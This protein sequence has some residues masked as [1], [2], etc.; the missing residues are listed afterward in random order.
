MVPVKGPL[1]LAAFLLF[2]NDHRAMQDRT[3]S[4][5]MLIGNPAEGVLTIEAHMGGVPSVMPFAEVNFV[6]QQTG[7][8][9]QQAA[10]PNQADE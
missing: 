9:R 8:D 2:Q 1:F 6:M 7:H 10:R 5:A 3:Y 4:Q